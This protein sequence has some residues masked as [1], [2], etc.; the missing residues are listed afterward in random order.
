MTINDKK[1]N[2][3]RSYRNIY[4]TLGKNVYVDE[5]AVIIGDINIGDD[6][7]IWPLVAIRG[8]VN[9]I[10]IGKRTNV[11]DGS[12]LHV[13]RKS[14]QLPQGYPLRIGDD[15]TIGH[16]CML[17]G[18]RLG[19]RI[20]VGMGAIIMD[21]AHIEDDVIIAA[22]SLISPN[23]RLTSGFMY[24]GRPAKPAR[25]LT[26]QELAFLTAS[27]HNYVELKQEYLLQQRN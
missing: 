10:N 11:Q 17:H 14:S 20:L 5:A 24:V 1:P 8:D 13:T 19:N 25:P 23:K 9:S 12:I 3:Y 21:N 22:G 26:T 15:V 7:S 2:P 18:C 16:Q 27:A 4:P 6:S